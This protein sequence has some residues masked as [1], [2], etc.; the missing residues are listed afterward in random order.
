MQA[1]AG[2][3]KGIRNIGRYYYDD[4]KRKKNGEFDVVLEFAD[5]YDVYEAK[6]LKNPM[7]LTM[8][9]HEAGQIRE[10]P[11]ITVRQIGFISAS[12]FTKTE[13]GYQYLDGTALYPD[14]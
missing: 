4:P 6:F 1:H 12:G 13:E 3:L 14:I 10:I 7:D 8:Q 11:G 5:G 2:K 9:H